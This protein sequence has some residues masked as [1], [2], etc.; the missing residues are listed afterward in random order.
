LIEEVFM[1]QAQFFSLH[2]TTIINCGILSRFEWAAG[3]LFD[4]AGAI[5]YP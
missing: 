4:N 1:V 5:L 2:I 3:L